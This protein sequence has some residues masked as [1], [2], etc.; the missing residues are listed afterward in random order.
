VIV[1]CIK[2]V[3][4][5]TNNYLPDV[6]CYVSVV[7]L[8]LYLKLRP[9]PKRNFNPTGLHC[10]YLHKCFQQSNLCIRGTL[11]VILDYLF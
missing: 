1:K 3:R 2:L 4:V 11:I 10:I 7:K 6:E 8:V 9:K 5:I